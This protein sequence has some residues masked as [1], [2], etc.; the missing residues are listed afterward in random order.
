MNIHI[1]V[2]LVVKSTS[3]SDATMAWGFFNV[4]ALE[5]VAFDGFVMRSMAM[6]ILAKDRPRLRVKF[7]EEENEISHSLG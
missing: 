6:I 5:R 7:L 1:K 4:C 3:G 2:H